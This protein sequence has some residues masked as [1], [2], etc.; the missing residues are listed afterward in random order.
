MQSWLFW[1]SSSFLTLAP[2]SISFPHD[3]AALDAET[4]NCTQYTHIDRPAA[5]CNEGPSFICTAGCVGAVV[6][7][8]C[9]LEGPTPEQSEQQICTISYSQPSVDL[10]ICTNDLG[11]FHC[12]GVSE[13]AAS[14]SGCKTSS[15]DTLSKNNSEAEGIPSFLHNETST[16]RQNRQLR[17]IGRAHV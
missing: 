5:T 6:A 7:S 9:T 4:L 2:S 12:E 17:E 13:G 16:A 8:A 15:L 3:G 1:A 14:C 10:G 11:T